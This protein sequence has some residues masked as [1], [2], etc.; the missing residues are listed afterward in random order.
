MPNKP[1]PSFQ[2]QR[3]PPDDPREWLNRARS[4]LARARMGLDNPEIYLERAGYHLSESIKRAAILPT[5][6]VG[7]R[8][9]GV[10]EWVTRQ[11]YEEMVSNADEVVRWAQGIIDQQMETGA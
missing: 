8:Y 10:E 9:P 1:S 6:A 4:N 3:F 11:E 5:Y 2:E 7:T